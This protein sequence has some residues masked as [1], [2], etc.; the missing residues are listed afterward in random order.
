VEGRGPRRRHEEIEIELDGR[1]YRGERSVS[2]EHELAQ[3]VR[4]EA[5]RVRDPNDY[6]AGDEDLMHDV[7]RKILRDLVE[8]T[9]GRGPLPVE[10]RATPQRERGES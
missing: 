4:F 9:L 5:S 6:D 8:Q 7:A 3:E 2:G 10:P 1:S